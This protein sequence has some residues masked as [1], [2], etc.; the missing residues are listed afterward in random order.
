MNIEVHISFQISG[1][2]FSYIYSGVEL[3]GHMVVLFFSFLGNLHT[4]F[5]SGC[6][7]L[8]SHQQCTGVPFSPHPCQHLLFVF[9]LMTGCLT[10]VRWY[11][12]VVLIYISLM[13]SDVGYLF[14]CLSAIC[15]SCLEKCLFSSS[16]PFLIGLF[17]FLMLSCMSCLY[18]SLTPY[19]KRNSKWIKNLM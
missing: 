5:H 2:F 7:N 6:T 9:F 8:H 19:R 10:G 12:I 18:M 3:L 1:V 17:V 11:V 14:M 16:S 15:I 13:F 4:L